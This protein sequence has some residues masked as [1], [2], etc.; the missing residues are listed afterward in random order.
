MVLLMT[1]AY[2]SGVIFYIMVRMW[3]MKTYVLIG[4]GGFFGAIIRY[5]AGQIEPGAFFGQF[6]INTL[7][8]NAAGAFLLALILTASLEVRN[9]DNSLRLGLTTGFLG[10]LTTFS[11][12][13]KQIAGLFQT[14]NAGVAAL[15]LIVT[16]A[17]GYAA[18]SAGFGL[19]RAYGRTRKKT[20][21]GLISDAERDMD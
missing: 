2:N 8:V 18:A 12:L 1:S 19:A 11:T 17:L 5:S 9:M 21:G 14:G 3:R 4:A 6:P 20:K 10:A 13:C 15:Y 7:L 16:L